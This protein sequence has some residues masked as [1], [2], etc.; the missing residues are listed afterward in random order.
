MLGRLGV[1]LLS[2]LLVFGVMAAGASRGLTQALDVA[3]VLDR[4]AA[5]YGEKITVTVYVFDRGLPVEPSAI[6]AEVDKLPGTAPLAL[7]RHSTGVYNGEFVFESHPSVVAA[8]ATVGD[9][10]DEGRA[11]VYHRF[12]QV[13][14]IPSTG[15]A[16][17]GQTIAI[18]VETR[19]RD[20]RFE[21]A[22]SIG[23]TADVV[24]APEFARQSLSTNLTFTRTGTGR[25]SAAFTVPPDIDRDAMVGIRADVRS[26]SGGTGVGADVI[27]DFP[28]NFVVWYRASAIVGSN[29]TLEVDVASMTGG[30]S[31]NATVSLRIWPYNRSS[32]IDMEGSTD[33]SGAVSFGVSLSQIPLTFYGNVT[34]GPKRQPFAGVLGHPQ[35]SNPAEP[36]IVRE[37]PNEIFEA[38]ETAVLRFRL[39]TGVNPILDQELFVYA[40]T[41]SDLVLAERVQTDGGGRFEVRFVAPSRYVRIDIAGLLDGTWRAFRED[42]AAI[43]RLPVIVSSSDGWHL[44]ISGSFPTSPDAWIARLSVS[45]EEASASQWIAAETFWAHRVVGGSGGEPFGFEITLPRFLSVGQAV[46]LEIRAESFRGAYHLFRATVVTGTPILRSTNFDV[47]VPIVGLGMVIALSAVGLR[48]RRP[49][50]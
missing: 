23:I 13:L 1:L 34:S 6:S 27:V 10:Q 32:P 40:Q 9:T 17:P 22:D 46:S 7:V 44:T 11:V 24:F 48:R 14:I 4:S 47:L 25:Y 3:V 16:R 15:T 8:T 21:D 30:P 5:G 39:V 19:D 20:G 12:N 29:A 31:P 33:S 50:E 45:T 43:D 49:R 26:R 2:G 42:F 37:N 28:D 38:G 41:A 18:A 36:K 35:T